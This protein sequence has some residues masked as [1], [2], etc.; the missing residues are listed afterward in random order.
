MIENHFSCIRVSD[1][2]IC[3]FCYSTRIIKNGT[4]K[5][6]KQQYFCKNCSLRFVDFYTYKAYLQ[7]TNSLIIQF[8]KDGL[9]IRSIAR[10][11]NISATKLGFEKLMEV[12]RLLFCH[13]VKCMNWTRCD[14]SSERKPIQYSWYMQLIKYRKKLLDSIL[15]REITKH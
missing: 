7:N 2:G 13:S 6:K 1:S 10:V 15:E 11:L 9:G 12:S 14:S 3:P 5:T 4:T 8:T